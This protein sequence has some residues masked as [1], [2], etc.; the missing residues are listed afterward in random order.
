[1]K[2]G[3]VNTS[4]GDSLGPC[5]EKSTRGTPFSI[6]TNS[7][8]GP[9]PLFRTY[10]SIANIK[11]ITPDHKPSNMQTQD[12]L[13]ENEKC[14]YANA[15][16]LTL[17]WKNSTYYLKRVNNYS[18]VL[19]NYLISKLFPISGNGNI[20]PYSISEQRRMFSTTNDSSENQ[21]K[22]KKEE[23]K[24]LKKPNLK[25]KM[26]AQSLVK[27]KSVENVNTSEDN[28]KYIKTMIDRVYAKTLSPKVSN[29]VKMEDK[30]ILKEW[31][32]WY[33]TRINGQTIQGRANVSISDF[34][35]H[36]YLFINSAHNGLDQ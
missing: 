36:I 34:R 35:L 13:I 1:M 5:Q 26:F 10:H 27:I 3:S 20:L 18:Y 4:S 33:H 22:R 8:K 15:K 28:K 9:L 6:P 12:I 29:Y 7:P 16:Q 19:I 32:S 25:N 14:I 21:Y 24:K 2:P 30:S 23:R 17:N 31:K 11:A